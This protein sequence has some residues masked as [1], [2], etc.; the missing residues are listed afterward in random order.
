MGYLFFSFSFSFF[1]SLS[2]LGSVI[3]Y[4]VNNIYGVIGPLFPPE[5]L[6]ITSFTKV[7]GAFR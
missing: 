3:I 4:E 6:T 1:A 7:L 2:S 5:T